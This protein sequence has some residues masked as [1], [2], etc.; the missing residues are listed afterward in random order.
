M[1]IS[2][3]DLKTLDLRLPPSRLLDGADTMNPDP[4]YSAVL[5]VLPRYAFGSRAC[6]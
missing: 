6:D 2:I 4:D 1:S 3:T 5:A